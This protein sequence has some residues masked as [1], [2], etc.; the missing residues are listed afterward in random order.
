MAHRGV[1]F[2]DEFTE[3]NRRILESLRQPL[4][5]K[6]VTISRAK[7]S[8]TYPSNTMLLA[9]MNPCPCGF[10]GSGQNSCS[11]TGQQIQNYLGKISGPL[12]DRIDI[13]IEAP[14]V[15]KKDLLTISTSETSEEIRKRV[16]KARD[17]QR[18][19]FSTDDSDVQKQLCYSNS[20]MNSREV[21]TFCPL[22]TQNLALIDKMF[23]SLNFSARSYTKVLKIARTI[24]DLDDSKNIQQEHLLEAIQYRTLDRKY[25]AR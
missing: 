25:W 10:H 3:F 13:H 4:E 21:T 5:D 22:N 8:A 14:A 15:P 9:A 12:L 6:K 23:D 11:C 2:L 24:A 1:L 20:D 17:I 18:K 7:R 19:R 16:E